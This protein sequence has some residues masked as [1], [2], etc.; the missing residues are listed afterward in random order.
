[1]RTVWKYPL[2]WTAEPQTVK[3]PPGAA[4]RRF[5]MQ[6]GTAT[7]WAEVNVPDDGPTD[8]EDR[9]FV[10]VGTGSPVPEGFAT[11]RGTVDHNGFVFHLYEQT[12]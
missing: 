6:S 9:R 1:M 5:A 12:S 4:P 3:M 7:V 10:I 11:Y 8:P 2:A